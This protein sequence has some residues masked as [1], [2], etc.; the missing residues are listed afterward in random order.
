MKKTVLFL[1]S[2]LMLSSCSK[3]SPQQQAEMEQ[4]TLRYPT[5]PVPTFDADSAFSY[6][7]KQVDFG[8]RNPNSVAHDQCLLYLQHE[9]SRYADTV[10]LE[11]F[12]VPGYDGVVLHLTNIIASFNMRAK[13][14]VLLS[15]HWDSRPR[16][17]HQPGGP[18]DKPIPGA[19]DGASGVA[20]LLEMA[21]DFKQSP[22]PVG[23]DIMLWDGEDYGKEGELDYY[24]LG[25]KYWAATKPFSYQPDFAVNLDMIGQKD[26][27]IDKEGYSVQYAPD[28]VDLIWNAAAELG[29]PQFVDHVGDTIY[30][31][32]VPLQNA[33]IKAVDLI[34]FNYK[35][36]HTLEDTP[37]KCSPGSLSAVGRVL[38]DVLY[39]KIPISSNE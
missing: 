36:W 20:V 2:A 35:Y 15:A 24:C 17:D 11:E 1:L 6:L 8:P 33:G 5:V 39:R 16:A 13:T 29:V 23:V 30:D 12:N 21:R 3:R 25:S 38:L 4:R 26:L 28:I 37:D 19:D 31:D 7:V 34:D 27:K 18:V 32:H 14:R 9:F 22:P 10:Q